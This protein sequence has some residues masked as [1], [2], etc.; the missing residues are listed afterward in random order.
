MKSI[1][2]TSLWRDGLWART[3]DGNFGLIVEEITKQSFKTGPVPS[4][5]TALRFVMINLAHKAGADPRAVCH[6]MWP[7][8]VN[9]LKVIDKIVF[10]TRPRVSMRGNVHPLDSWLIGC[11]VCP[12]P[13]GL[14]HD[15]KGSYCESLILKASSHTLVSHI[16][17]E[18]R[19]ILLCGFLHFCR[20]NEYTNQEQSSRKSFPRRFLKK[21]KNLRFLALFCMDYFSS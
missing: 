14:I 16:R 7:L 17:F 3:G 15:I 12:S 8:F 10:W 19:M 9:V 1:F 2:I 4:E 5:R 18:T 20:V 13:I 11:S 21:M 6:R